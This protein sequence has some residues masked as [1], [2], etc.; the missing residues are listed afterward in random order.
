[1]YEIYT[2]NT[3]VAWCYFGVVTFGPINWLSNS[4][5]K[6]LFEYVTL[7]NRSYRDLY[8]VEYVY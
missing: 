4:Q 3:G 6:W 8:T 1:M 2:F 5:K 7:P